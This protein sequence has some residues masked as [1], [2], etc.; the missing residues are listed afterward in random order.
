MTAAQVIRFPLER[1]RPEPFVDLRAV[2]DHYG[3]S[4]RWIRYQ[5]ADGMPSHR[6]CKRLLRF[7]L[8][9]VQEW[10]DRRNP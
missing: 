1:T 10:F 3:R 7:K 9:E 5:L 8:S 2:M 6:C 4:E